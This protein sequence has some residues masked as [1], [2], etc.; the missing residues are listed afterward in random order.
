MISLRSINLLFLLSLVAL[1]FNACQNKPNEVEE[2]SSSSSEESSSS[3]YFVNRLDATY[4]DTLISAD[5]ANFY[6]EEDTLTKPQLFYLGDL[7]A[8]TQIIIAAA[9]TDIEGDTI[10]VYE[11]SGTLVQTILP[12]TDSKGNYVYTYM[13]PG[14][15]S[16]LI[17]NQFV[18]LKEGHYYLELKG[19]IQE[20]SHLRIFTEI[21]EAYYSYLGDSTEISINTQDTLRGL[22]FIG[23]G[24]KQ[25]DISIKTSTGISLNI[26]ASG[27]W[28]TKYTLTE[29]KDTIETDTAQIDKLLLPQSKTTYLL[30]LKPFTIQNYLTGPYAFFELIT[31]SRDLDKG[32]YLAYPDSVVRPGDT[33]TVVRPRNDQAKYYLRQEQYVWLSDLKKG[34]TLFIT[35][36]MEGYYSGPLYPAS[37][38]ILNADGDSIQSISLSNYI[39]VAPKDGAYYLHYLRLDSP[40]SDESQILTLKT[41]TQQPNLLTELHFYD[42]ALESV[43]ENKT[44]KQGDTLQFSDISFTTAPNTAS[45]NV[46]WYVPC[47]DLHNLSSTTYAGISCTGDQ[48]MTTNLVVALGEPGEKASLIAESLADPNKRDTLTVYIK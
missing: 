42:E 4:L 19:K 18:T 12:T 6:F 34:D 40:P 9:T 38:T 21:N 1:C 43:I 36:E 44:L 48:L 33:L 27:S 30:S 10:R 32:E 29:G 7:K 20:G 17:T 47:E 45:K 11:E 37:L 39:F 23:Q 8:G 16:E 13:L 28:I 31:N 2:T 22:F 5:T 3:S 26:D 35:H 41:F 24:A 25:L 14:A 15:G 46:L